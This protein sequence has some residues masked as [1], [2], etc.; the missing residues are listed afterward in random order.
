MKHSVTWNVY[1][2]TSPRNAS[3]Y[4]QLMYGDYPCNVGDLYAEQQPQVSAAIRKGY[5][6]SSVCADASHGTVTRSWISPQ[7]RQPSPSP[8]MTCPELYIQCLSL[9]TAEHKESFSPWLLPLERSRVVGNEGK[10]T[11]SL[12]SA[13]DQ[14]GQAGQTASHQPRWG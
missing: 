8:A 13:F 3:R 10:K 2:V 5:T 9:T 11:L 12:H 4:R 7:I 1:I 6:L 14:F